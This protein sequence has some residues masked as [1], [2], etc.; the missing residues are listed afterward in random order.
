MFE[1]KIQNMN[2]EVMKRYKMLQ[3]TNLD[4]EPDKKK[5]IK[6]KKMTI[7]KRRNENHSQL[8]SHKGTH[9]NYLPKYLSITNNLLG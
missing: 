1:Y 6:K 2:K 7:T 8:N 4:K 5:I 9:A 3:Y